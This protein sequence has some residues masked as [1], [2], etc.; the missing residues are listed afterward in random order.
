MGDLIAAKKGVTGMNNLV[1]EGKNTYIVQAPP[2]SSPDIVPSIY[3]IEL[4]EGFLVEWLWTY[5]PDGNRV[6]T[7]YKLIPPPRERS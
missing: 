5:L 1:K 2:P 4:A 6:V 3:W 7:D